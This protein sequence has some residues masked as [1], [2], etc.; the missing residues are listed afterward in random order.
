M[1]TRVLALYSEERHVHLVGILNNDPKTF[2]LS[3]LAQSTWMLGYPEQALGISDAGAD[4]ARGAG[5]P[6]TWVGR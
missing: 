6:F 4:H 3:L 2:S 1:P 5:T